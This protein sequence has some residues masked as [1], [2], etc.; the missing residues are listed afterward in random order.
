MGLWAAIIAQTASSRKKLLA[1]GTL[2]CGAMYVV[3]DTFAKMT[4][5]GI[6]EKQLKARLEQLPYDQRVR[7]YLLLIV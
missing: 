1:F 2:T 4:A 6:D 3:G 7:G 5:S